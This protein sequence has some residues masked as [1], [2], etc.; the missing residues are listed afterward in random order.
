MREGRG[1]GTS[2]MMSVKLRWLLCGRDLFVVE[3]S[4]KG[5]RPYSTFVRYCCRETK[6]CVLTVSPALRCVCV[7]LFFMRGK[8]GVHSLYST[9]EDGL[10]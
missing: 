10:R 5:R 6:W 2:S 9:F 3:S 7:V 8:V 4:S 1:V